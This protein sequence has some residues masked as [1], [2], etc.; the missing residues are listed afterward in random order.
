MNKSNIRKSYMLRDLGPYSARYTS[1]GS[2]LI[3]AGFVLNGLLK[4]MTIDEAR[5][6]SLDGTLLHQ[7]THASRHKKEVIATI[8]GKVS[9][10]LD[11]L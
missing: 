11:N 10:F 4:G 2:L 7:R 9:S 6:R 5:K 3:E 1:K 8:F